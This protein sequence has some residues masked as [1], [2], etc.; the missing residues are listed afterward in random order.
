M[1]LITKEIERKLLK[2]GAD[3]AEGVETSDREPVVKFFCPWGSATWLI[4]EMDPEDHSM[5]FG[6]CDLGVGFPELGWVYLPEL[7]E[8]RGPAGLK[9][10]RDLY[11]TPEGTLADYADRSRIE[12]RIVA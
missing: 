4:T 10:E 8:V 6:L 12:G 11:F 9:I 7:E 3:A 1:K 5:L 2:N